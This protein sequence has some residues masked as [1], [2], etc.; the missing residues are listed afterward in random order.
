MADKVTLSV[1]KMENDEIA[2]IVL[3]P[4]SHVDNKF[5]SEVMN[6]NTEN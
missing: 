2:K 6:E 4:S 3:R 1:D 5:Y